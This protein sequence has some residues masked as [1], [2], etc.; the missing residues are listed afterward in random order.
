MKTN[1]FFIAALAATALFASCSKENA[2]T[3]DQ[4]GEKAVLSIGVV[5]PELS[6]AVGT[7]STDATVVNFKAFVVD[8]DNSIKSGYS[9]DGTALSVANSNAITVSTSAKKVYVIA[10]AGDLALATEA[11]IVDYIADLNTA[12]DGL[13]TSARWA[14][15]TATLVPTDFVQSGSDFVATKNVTLTFI[16]ARITVNIAKSGEMATYYDNGTAESKD[17]RITGVSVMNARGASKLFG[18]SL[19]ATPAT[20]AKTFYQGL[21]NP[22]SPGNF[23]YYPAAADFTMATALLSDAI[24][25][26]DNTT[27][28]NL[29]ASTYYYYVFENAAITA[30]AFPTIVTVVGEYDGKAIYFPVHLAA[31]EDFKSGTFGASLLRGKSY[32]LTIT[33]TGDPRFSEGGTY[34]GDTGGTEDPTN[35][36]V[37]AKVEVDVTLT[38]WVP[39]ALEK[40]F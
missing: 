15:G 32:D 18:A 10:N 3:N 12:G 16:A 17:L 5:A 9:S 24:P 30:A 37:S 7:P 8:G 2:G 34:P 6:R 11:A 20:P 14:T 4:T 21:A 38:P 36:S 28:Y 22:V 13:Q 25:A 1:K 31:Y 35:P 26:A 33:L 19:V 29:G 27:S 40:E 39:V 23:A